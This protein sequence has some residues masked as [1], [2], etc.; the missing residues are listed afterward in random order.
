MKVDHSD[1]DDDD[2]SEAVSNQMGKWQG[3]KSRK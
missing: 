3:E 1:D 2:Q